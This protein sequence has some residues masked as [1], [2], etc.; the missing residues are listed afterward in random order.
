MSDTVALDAAVGMQTYGRYP[1]VMVRG[2]GTE[3]W[4]DTGKRY[5]DFLAGIAVCSLGHAHPEIAAVI[6]DQAS[7]LMHTSNFFL[8]PYQPQLAA[9]IDGL[10]GGGGRVFFCNSGAEA[11]EAGFKLARRH[12]A[13]RGASAVV[14][15]LGS[16]H[17]RTM[18]ALSLTGQEAKRAPFEPLVPGVRFVPY[19]DAAALDASVTDDVAAVL[20][21]PIQGEGGVIPAPPGYL[22][23]ARA[24]CDRVGALL[25]IDEVQTGFGRTGDWFAFQAEGIQPD[26]VLMAKALGNGM[27]IGACWARGDAAN[28]LVAGDHGTT[29]G[30]QPLAARTALTVIDVMAETDVRTRARTRGAQLAASLLALEGVQAVRG[31]GLLLAAEL[32]NGIDAKAVALQALTAGLIVNAVSPTALRFA[33]PLLVTPTEVDEAVAILATVLSEGA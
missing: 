11:N 6:A 20:I 21:E 18:G 9:R 13:A 30:G 8:N 1:I 33:P 16:F 15:T 4:D 27:P 12:G 31:R 22:A 7:T 26:V 28:A 24:A 2:A 3:L 14:S 17:G 10:L 25:I 5:L 19:G 23:A 29:F 32:A